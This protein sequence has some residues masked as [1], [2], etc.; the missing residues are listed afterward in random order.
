MDDIP[1]FHNELYLAY[2]LSA[3]AHANIISVDPSEAL[4]QPGVHAYFCGND[5]TPYQNLIGPIN[6]D[7]ELFITKTCTSLGQ[8]I[9]VIIA[10]DQTLA[11]RAARK[12]KVVYEELSPII[13]SIE[14]AV[15]KKSFFPGFPR[16]IKKGDVEKAFKEVDY[17]IE[18][19]CRMGGQEHFYLETHCALAVPKREDDE[20]EIFCSSQHPSEIAV[21]RQPY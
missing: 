12:V 21:S 2:V 5:L 10:E 4:A 11:Q 18:D 8:I 16:V 19:D 9:G 13:V 6:H 7:E 20:I 3:K 14:D 15:A 17:I 1:K